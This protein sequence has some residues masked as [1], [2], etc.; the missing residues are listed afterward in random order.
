MKVTKEENITRAAES[1]HI[2]QPYLSKQLMELENEFGKQLLIRGKRKI[3][4]TEDEIILR[5]R[6][7]EILSLVKKTESDLNSNNPQISG[8]IAISGNPT[9]TV[10]NAASHLRIHYPD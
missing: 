2:L 9:M 1:L 3:I 10:L 5:K 8:E 6:A 4:L 7:E